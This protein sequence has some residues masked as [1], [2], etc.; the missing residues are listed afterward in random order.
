MMKDEVNKDD[1]ERNE[2]KGRKEGIR[3]KD[4]I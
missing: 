2:Y 3:R 4:G 1:E